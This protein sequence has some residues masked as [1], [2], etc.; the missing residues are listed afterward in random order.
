MR[1]HEAEESKLSQRK[2]AA[3]HRKDFWEENDEMKRMQSDISKATQALRNKKIIDR[4]L[5]NRNAT[6]VGGIV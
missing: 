1:I 4:N 5:R 2:P 6:E 3:P